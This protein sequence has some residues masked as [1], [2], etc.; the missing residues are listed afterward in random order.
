VRIRWPLTGLSARSVDSRMPCRLQ[1]QTSKGRSHR[2]RITCRA[3]SETLRTMGQV[4]TGTRVVFCEHQDIVHPFHAPTGR[5]RDHRDAKNIK[6]ETNPRRTNTR[7]AKSP[8][9]RAPVGIRDGPRSNEFGKTK[10]KSLL[11]RVSRVRDSLGGVCFDTYVDGRS[12]KAALGRWCLMEE[13]DMP[14]RTTRQE[15]RARILAAFQ[16]QLDRMIP[17]DE[18]VPLKGATFADFE[19]QV[20]ELARSALPVAL[21][22]RAALECNAE[23]VTAGRCPHCGSARV[24]LEKQVTTPEVGS[25]HGPVVLH[26]Q[27]ARCRA[28]GGSFSPSGS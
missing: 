12:W 28:C 17:V 22:E 10:P 21:E 7:A 26:K 9:F 24:Y 19:D 13:A 2:R 25:A 6:C 23:V 18:E 14:A 27:H 4:R 3:L 20:E 16:A 15:A 5:R 11:P 8:F 1:R